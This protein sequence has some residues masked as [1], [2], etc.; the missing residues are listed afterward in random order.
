VN[1]VVLLSRVVREIPL[2]E[3]LEAAP[4]TRA[5]AP[6]PQSGW[7]RWARDP[8]LRFAII[9]A[10]IFAAAHY[11]EQAKQAEQTRIT[12]D[13][14]LR[15]RLAGLYRTQFGAAPGTAQLQVIVDDY[16]DDE[17]LY[18]EALRL[19][20]AEDDE[21]VRRRL[22]QKLEFL[23]RDAVTSTNPTSDELRAYY[24]GHPGQFTSPARTT[25]TQVFFNP[26]HGG[27]THALAR[28]RE[29]RT[30]WLAR[31]EVPTGDVSSLESGY[32]GVTRGEVARIFGASAFVDAALAQPGDW[33]E[34][35][36][37]GYGWHLVRVTD[38]EP[39]RT[40]PFEQVLP[41][42]RAAYLNEASAR[43][44]RAQLDALR[45]QYQLG[46]RG[47]QP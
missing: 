10:A 43:A 30:A 36:R 25:F 3:V 7:R 31:A 4:E 46:A 33:S 20:L 24:D 37:S 26:D 8:L 1:T 44:R 21:I 40:L 29:A 34:P 22:I 28:A 2:S 6:V 12:V 16:L 18:R 13:A 15:A 27:D 32:S 5:P 42:V 23:R 9:G 11:I 19:G 38:A 47:T 17:V 45:V 35:V 39:A 41:D 14:G